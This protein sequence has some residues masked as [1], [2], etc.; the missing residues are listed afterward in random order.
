MEKELENYKRKLENNNENNN[1]NINEEIPKDK[2]KKELEIK[3]MK[4]ESNIR[5]QKERN[6]NKKEKELKKYNNLIEN[7][8][9]YI[10]ELIKTKKSRLTLQNKNKINKL[11]RDC[12]KNFE[13]M[14]NEIKSKLNKEINLTDDYKDHTNDFIL[15][16][17]NELKEKLE[18]EKKEI[19]FEYEQN[20][21]KELEDYKIKTKNDKEEK[22]ELLN[23]DINNLEKKYY[24]ELDVMKKDFSDK[25]NKDNDYMKNNIQRNNELLTEIKNNNINKAN[26]EI[27][28]IKDSITNKSRNKNDY[29]D[30]EIIE[31]VIDEFITD[32][33]TNMKMK[34]NKIKSLFDLIEKEYINKETNIKYI[35]KAMLLMS[36]IINEKSCI[37]DLDLNES[38][39]IKNKDESLVNEIFLKINIL[40]NEFGNK[41]DENYKYK[42]KNNELYSF[43]NKEYKKIMDTAYKDNENTIIF[44]NLYSKNNRYNLNSERKQNSNNSINNNFSYRLNN[45]NRVLNKPNNEINNYKS[46][47]YNNNYNISLL[48]SNSPQKRNNNIYNNNIAYN[49]KSFSEKKRNKNVILFNNNNNISNLPNGISNYINNSQD[50]NIKEE[51][52]SITSSIFS[53]ND[54]NPQLPE[55]ILQKFSKDIKNLYNSINLFLISESNKIN[56]EIKDLN[57][58]KDSYKKLKELNKYNDVFSQI[59]ENEKSIS[60]KKKKYI[61][62]KLK[63]F[64]MIKRNCDENF[65]YICN[66]AY[67]ENIFKDKLNILL[68]H[69]NDYNKNYNS[70]KNNNKNQLN[71]EVKYLDNNNNINNN[72][73]V[74][75][76]YRNDNNEFNNKI[77]NF[78]NSFATSK[79]NNNKINNYN[80]FR[81][82]IDRY[83]YKYYQ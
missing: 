15:E 69:I 82:N 11:E 48:S 64:N 51:E 17:S 21:I 77:N 31:V 73:F 42:N 63:I 81:N 18:E 46:N 54:I 13:K 43:L 20:M 74:S 61:E 58:K 68:T 12:T 16:Y 2:N 49:N 71:F 33:L 30:S 41:E 28:E 66:N 53:P 79:D 40:N 62:D 24:S 14:K 3:K 29:N 67:R 4:I 57:K 7:K 60:N 44:T 65:D 59:Y 39:D 5:I 26:K 38:K 45:T 76:R 8:K 25:N 80:K 27:N 37:L 52:S 6:K 9:G 36:K 55:E 70:K 78:R 50:K 47:V 35:S 23:D 22:I 1:N 19:E 10:D 32:K 83:N 75:N 34:L 72:L 56:E